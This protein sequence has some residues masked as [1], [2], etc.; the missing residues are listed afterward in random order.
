MRKQ[1]RACFLISAMLKS[2]QTIGI[3]MVKMNYN[4]NKAQED[5]APGMEQ[6][7]EGAVLFYLWRQRLWNEEQNQIG[8]GNKKIKKIKTFCQ[9]YSSI[10]IEG[11]KDCCFCY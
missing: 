9:M 2:N 1:S 4:Q 3:R 8:Y 7:P 6:M 10:L 11:C 5:S